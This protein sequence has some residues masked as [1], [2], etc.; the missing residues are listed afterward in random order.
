MVVDAKTLKVTSDIPDLSGIHGVALAHDLNRGFISNGGD[1]TVTVFDLK[2]LKK[3][4]SVKVGERP[5][6]I[7]YEPFSKHVF[8][9]NAR[10]QD[11]TVVDAA[12][13]KVVGDNSTGRQA[14]VPRQRWQ[15]QAVRQH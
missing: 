3:L 14:G 5:D 8:T 2:T 13:G 12:T 15:G 11:S 9:F 1:N 10:S 7:L 4:D 6:A